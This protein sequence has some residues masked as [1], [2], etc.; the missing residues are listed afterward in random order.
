MSVVYGKALAVEAWEDVEARCVRDLPQPPRET[1][2]EL[3]LV[4]YADGEERSELIPLG[5]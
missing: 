5:S 4:F 3:E 1:V 2:R